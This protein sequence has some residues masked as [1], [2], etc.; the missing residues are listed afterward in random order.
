MPGQHRD[1][2]EA[3]RR[4]DRLPGRVRRGGGHQAQ[5]GPLALP[6]NHLRG[7]RR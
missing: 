7:N 3:K 5:R 1:P 6:V 4:R 2:G